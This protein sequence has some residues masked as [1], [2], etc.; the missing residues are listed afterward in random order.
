MSAT[1]P[2][3]VVPRPNPQARLRLICFPH[4]GA[5]A[6]TFTAWAAALPPQ[7]EVGAVQLPGREARLSEPAF[8][9]M[10]PLVAAL[11]AA[12][13][14]Q[15]AGRPFA[16]FGHSMGA[17]VSYEL[18]RRLQAEGTPPVHMFVSGHP[19]PQLPDR[20]APIHNLPEPEFTARLR[21]LNGTPPEVLEHPELRDLLLPILRADFTVCDTYTFAPGEPLPCSLSAFGG[22]QDPHA[23]RDELEAWREH[24]R[25]TFA[26]RLFP[27][28]H[29]YINSARPLLLRMVARELDQW[30]RTGQAHDPGFAV[31]P[32]A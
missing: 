7:I 19:A 14:P 3:L 6:S 22:L 15:L 9:Q 8:T 18:A 4:S 10:A 25:G 23:R 1:S 26:A 5:G 17:L 11:H 32:A 27:G 28:D 31:G 20:E 13:R 2:W 16:F 12:L 29:F 24:T 21:Q 30:L